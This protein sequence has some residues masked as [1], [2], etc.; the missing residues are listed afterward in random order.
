MENRGKTGTNGYE[1]STKRKTV[2][3]QNSDFL[4]TV[5]KSYDND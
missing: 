5:T 1:D 3:G 2:F 4:E